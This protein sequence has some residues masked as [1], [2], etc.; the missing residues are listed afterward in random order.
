[1]SALLGSLLIPSGW[2]HVLPQHR[3]F[4]WRYITIGYFLVR[5]SLSGTGSR[6]RT[7]WWRRWVDRWLVVLG[8][9]AVSRRMAV[10][11]WGWGGG[12]CLS[13]V[14][15]LWH[16]AHIVRLYVSNW[17]ETHIHPHA[18]LISANDN[19]TVSQKNPCDYVFDDNLNSKRPIVIIF[20]TVIT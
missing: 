17:T 3:D 20:G 6:R 15:D 2:R 8:V 10:S 19:Y 11:W 9:T 18:V 16:A 14:V 4:E 5:A 12:R 7:K 13:Q 1:M